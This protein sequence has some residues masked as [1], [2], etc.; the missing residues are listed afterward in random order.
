MAGPGIS[1][2]NAVIMADGSLPI[3]MIHTEAHPILIVLADDRLYLI[4]RPTTIMTILGTQMQTIGDM[5]EATWIL[6]NVGSGMLLWT[7]HVL[8][9]PMVLV[10]LHRTQLGVV[11]S[12][13]IYLHL[14]VQEHNCPF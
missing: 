1:V 14:E 12:L 3:Q 9:L 2:P 8:V 7:D 5:I 10:L 13:S 6:I 11:L 4:A